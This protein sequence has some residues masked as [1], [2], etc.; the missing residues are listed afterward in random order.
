MTLV[1]A[2][3]RGAA[4]RASLGV[5]GVATMADA[6]RACAWLG[7]EREPDAPMPGRLYGVYYRGVVQVRAG[8]LPGTSLFVLAHEL[9]HAV[10]GHARGA[11]RTPLLGGGPE[12]SPA[13]EEAQAFAF[14]FLLGEPGRTR[15]A[16]DA[17]LH[18]GVGAG[19][20]VAWLF[21]CAGHFGAA[22]S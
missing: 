13:E 19:L 17:Q 16:I 10:C 15:A 6:E 20:P 11:Y 7:V 9:G 1:E 8:L 22:L 3:H 4:V 21:W 14:V 12:A 2:V 18:A 5:A